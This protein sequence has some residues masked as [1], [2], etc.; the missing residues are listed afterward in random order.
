MKNKYNLIDHTADFGIHVFGSDSK[1]LFANAA[2]ALF[3][4]I[5]D[6]NHLKGLDSCNIEVSGDDWSDL[7]VNWLREILYLWNGKEFLL[8]KVRILSLSETKLSA[9]VELDT[10]DPDRH[11]IKT[12]IKA[13]TYHQ[14]QVNSSPSGWEA[15]IIFDI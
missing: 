11:I 7:M 14:I 1:E 13:V 5:T 9:S 15:R 4:L 8:K 2:L 10:F 3:D 12:E 6:I